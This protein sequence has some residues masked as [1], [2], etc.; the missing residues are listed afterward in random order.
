MITEIHIRNEGS[1]CDVEKYVYISIFLRVSGFRKVRFL[2]THSPIYFTDEEK[3]ATLMQLYE[4]WQQRMGPSHAP[5]QVS[6]FHVI[7]TEKNLNC[8]ACVFNIVNNKQ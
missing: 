8:Y 7:E 1:S 3:N 6:Y 2:L 5:I 4:N